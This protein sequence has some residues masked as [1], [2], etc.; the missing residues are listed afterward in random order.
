MRTLYLE[1][2]AGIAG[3]MFIGA[4]IDLGLFS[5]DEFISAMKGLDLDDYG[6]SIEKGLRRGISGI[7]FKVEVRSGDH[8]DGHDH[9]HR[10]RHLSDIL[11]ILERSSLPENVKNRSERAFRMLAQAEASVHGVD[12]ESIHFHEVGAVDSIVDVVGS[13][14]ALYMA[15]A[16]RVVSSPVNVGSG[17]VKCAHGVLPVPAPATA[18]LL[19][20]IPVISQG[21]PLERTTPTGALIL[22]TSVESYGSLP[23]GRIVATG[24]GLGD[25]DTELP[26]AL[27]IT[28]LEE[29]ED[30]KL[31]WIPGEAVVLEANVDD[32]NPQDFASAMEKLF[33]AGAWDVFLTSIMMKK[34][35]PG[36]RITCVCSLELERRC[37]EIILKNTSTI[38]LRCRRENRYTLRREETM[39]LTSLGPVRLKKA[40]WG[41][42]IVKRTVEY[43]DLKDISE[44]HTIP[45]MELR[46]RLTSELGVWTDEK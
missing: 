14:M 21:D 38:G 33:D 1:P 29:G 5:Q 7:D 15:G 28:L 41:D 2:F 32:M 27:R 16:D 31:P 10:H 37:S 18:R 45:L 19:E 26:N 36:T 35:R 3:D 25:K 13:F 12:L 34:Q 39:E 6:L 9:G 8:H 23:S 11:S 20:G 24:Y 42:R 46:D 4:M 17:T 40:Y 22:K 44:R 43:D 30:E